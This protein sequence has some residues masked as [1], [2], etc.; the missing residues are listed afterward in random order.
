LLFAIFLLLMAV[1]VPIVFAIGLS[2]VAGLL[3]ETRIPL[4][5]LVSKIFAGMDSFPLMAIPFFILT[6]HL[7][8]ACGLTERIILLADVLVGRR[9]RAGLA[10]VN[11][12]ASMIFSGIS[13]SVVA[14]SSAMGSVL[15]PGMTRAGYDKDYSVAVTA[16]SSTI[17]ALIPP[18]IIM[19]VYGFLAQ[20]SIGRLFLGGAI[21]GLL[22]GLALMVT[23]HLVAVR[24]GYSALD[25]GSDGTAAP[26]FVQAFRQAS[27][28]LLIPV[29]IIGGIVG[30]VFTPTEAGV[31][32]AVTVLVIGL[33]VYRSLR[34]SDLE[35]VFVEAA[36]TTCVVMMI[37]GASA[38]FANLLARARF[39]SQILDWLAAVTTDPTGQLL[40]IM[41]F[42]F[43][44]GFFVDVMAVLIMFAGALASVGAQLGFDAI[45]FGVVIVMITLI[46]ATTPPV[47]TL[48]ILCCG[49]ARIKLGDAMP[50]IW[51]FVA[52]LVA[53]NLLVAFVPELAL[54]LPRLVFG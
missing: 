41:G 19:V 10:H 49:I 44:F 23:A 17:G 12:V 2:S 50:I 22:V 16:T 45:H 34:W 6:G 46:G 21:P 36:L 18:S 3:L 38:I 47:G 54:F 14:D 25:R 7:A 8:N 5:I 35:E 37:L 31:V 43:V 13:G 53:V 15:I 33:F 29:I 27:L 24:R 30:G 52:A 32:A 51:P 4:T 1:G 40:L 39:Q 11:I 26:G 20:Q 48:L 9:L 28:A 42:L